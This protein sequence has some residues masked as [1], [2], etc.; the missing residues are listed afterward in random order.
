MDEDIE[1]LRREVQ[2]LMAMNTAAYLAITSLVATHPNPQQ[3]Q[4]HLIA[5]LEG[6][7][8]SERIAKWPE[9]QKAIVR[10]VMETFQQIQ[11][12]GHIDPLASA[13]GD[14]DPRSQP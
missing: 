14:R 12:A 13:L 9:D 1:A 2:H 6:I 5:S 4:L 8:G 10:R 7:L 11:P 3:L